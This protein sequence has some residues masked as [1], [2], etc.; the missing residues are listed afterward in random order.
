MYS[1]G[2]TFMIP[3]QM[4][5]QL[6]IIS[7]DWFSGVQ[8]IRPIFTFMNI[9]TWWICPGILHGLGIWHSWELTSVTTGYIEHV[10]VIIFDNI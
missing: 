2:L 6:S 9:S 7:A 3:A 4:T 10:M 1:V 5:H 8:R